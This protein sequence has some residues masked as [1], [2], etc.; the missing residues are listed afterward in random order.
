MRKKGEKEKE[1]GIKLFTAFRSIVSK[2]IKD[3]GRSKEAKGKGELEEHRK[4]TVVQ[5][6]ASNGLLP[7][8]LGD[9][10]REHRQGNEET[11]AAK[12]STQKDHQIDERNVEGV[13]KVE[14]R[15]CETPKE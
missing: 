8:F 14:R 15:A 1:K 7:F 9:R 3:K 11:D 2:T 10:I 12:D 4:D 5:G 6:F 13:D